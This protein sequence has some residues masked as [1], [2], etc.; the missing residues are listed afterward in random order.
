MFYDS[1]K[2]VFSK[3]DIKIKS[4]TN[5]TKG[6]RSLEIKS[7]LVDLIW[8]TTIHRY[9]RLIADPLLPIQRV[10]HEKI[11][12]KTLL[13]V[14]QISVCGEHRRPL[15]SLSRT[16][17]HDDRDVSSRCYELPSPFSTHLQT[18]L[19]ATDSPLH[20]RM[21]QGKTR[22]V[23]IPSHV[24]RRTSVHHY[25]LDWISF[26]ALKWESCNARASRLI[27]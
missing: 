11:R 22:V 27:Q 7:Q 13:P 21:K 8:R 12:G 6:P 20:S 3:Y 25:P 18:H 16:Q 4:K 26:I 9:N 24:F 1:I 10:R 19:P 23:K 5:E 17:A 14:F 2:Q 15:L